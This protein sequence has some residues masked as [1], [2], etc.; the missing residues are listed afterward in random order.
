MSFWDIEP[1]DWFR[2]F[3]SSS[4]GSGGG[5]L[6]RRGGGGWF[7]NDMPRQ[8]DE[9]KREME[10]MFEEQ[11]KEIQTKAPKELVR[12]YETPEGVKVREVGPLVYGYSTTIGPDGKPKVKRIW[13]C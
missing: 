11:F 8:I 2:R 12:E 10:R 5:Q 6:S 13:K 1:E 3:F 7:G 4:G 9:M